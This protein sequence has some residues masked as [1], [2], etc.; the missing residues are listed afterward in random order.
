MDD[1]VG[2]DSDDLSEGFDMGDTGYKLFEY[3]I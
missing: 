1:I 2:G 3:F